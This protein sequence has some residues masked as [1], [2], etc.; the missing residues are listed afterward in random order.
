MSLWLNLTEDLF[1]QLAST[2]SEEEQWK[3][4]CD[5]SAIE[6]ADDNPRSHVIMEAVFF[7]LRFCMDSKYSYDQSKS[8]MEIMQ[9]V[10]MN[11]I[12]NTS[13]ST[14]ESA[15]AM[16]K[17]ELKGRLALQTNDVNKTMTSLFTIHQVKD[18][19]VFFSNNMIKNFVAYQY[20]CCE[21]YEEKIDVRNISIGTPLAPLP[22][23]Q[24]N[25]NADQ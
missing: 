21:N 4:A 25:E 19:T 8:V 2:E 18:F 17:E 16:F 14:S 9:T 24:A 3:I 15:I 23:M 11:C 12:F 6:F 7:Y 5:S 22:L 20:V 10:F 1:T 13:E